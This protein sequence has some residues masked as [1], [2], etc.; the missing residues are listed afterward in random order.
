[1]IG[2]DGIGIRIEIGKRN[3]VKTVITD[4]FAFLTFIGEYD[5]ADHSNNAD[6]LEGINFS[7]LGIDLD[8]LDMEMSDFNLTSQLCPDLLLQ[9]DLTIDQVM[10]MTLEEMLSLAR[11]ATKYSVAEKMKLDEA[12]KARITEKNDK[13]VAALFLGPMLV[14]AQTVTAI[15]THLT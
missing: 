13:V 2:L 8:K 1:M 6:L 4:I 12:N 15:V 9:F 10:A 14:L 7:A 3:N 5:S 11:E